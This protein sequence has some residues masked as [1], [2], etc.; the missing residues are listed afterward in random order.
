VRTIRQSEN[1]REALGVLRSGAHLGLLSDLEVRRLH[2][3][4]VPFLGRPALTLTA[5][6]ALARAAGLPLLPAVCI[7]DA[8]AGRWRLSFEEP[9]AL[10]P[11]LERR[12]GR[13]DLLA[14]QN[15]V[16]GRWIRAHPEQ[17]AWH[18]PRWR[19]QPTGDLYKALI[20]D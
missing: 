3:E 12:A 2:G 18:Q 8:R 20:K 7:F 6:A 10:D 15:G 11:R 5:P 13:L 14:R 4:F 1:A 9:L 17:W 16:F 19:T